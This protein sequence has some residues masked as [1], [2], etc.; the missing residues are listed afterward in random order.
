MGENNVQDKELE[1]K[2]PLFEDNGYLPPGCFP[3]TLKEFKCRFVL[4][5]GDSNTR[6]E[7]FNEYI[8]YASDLSTYNLTLKKWVGGSYVSTKLDPS[9]MDMIVLYDGIE[10]NHHPE[11]GSFFNLFLRYHGYKQYLH[12]SMYIAVY[13]K[14]DPRYEAITKTQFEIW[15]NFI[16]TAKDNKTKRGLILFN[17]MSEEYLNTLTE[18]V[19]HQ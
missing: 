5:F 6:T 16:S 8:G 3:S 13:P 1:K 11:R 15:H 19:D 14:S 17:T 4:D 18:E 9:D 10:F 12:H 7:I 2:I